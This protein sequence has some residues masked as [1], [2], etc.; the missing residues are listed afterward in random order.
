MEELGIGFVP[1]GPFGKGFPAGTIG[2]DARFES[3]DIRGTVPRFAAENRKAN[4]ALVAWGPS[5]KARLFWTSAAVLGLGRP[6]LAQGA[7]KEGPTAG[8]ARD[9]FVGGS[10]NGIPSPLVLSC[11]RRWDG[12]VP[13]P[14][15][16]DGGE[17]RRAT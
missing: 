7:E 5:T 10:S 16:S 12:R 15:S 11:V 2:A 14:A 6:G 8:S 3:A 1:F 13:A 9:K 4:Q 17:S